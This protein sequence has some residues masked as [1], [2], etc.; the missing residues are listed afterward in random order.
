[1]Y[2]IRIFNRMKSH[3]HYLLGNRSL[4]TPSS[5]MSNTS[6]KLKYDIGIIRKKLNDNLVEKPDGYRRDGILFE[7]VL[8]IIY[9]NEGYK[10]INTGGPGDA[11]VDLI[12]ERDNKKI[13]IQAKNYNDKMTAK[14]LN[15]P[16]VEAMFHKIKTDGEG[17]HLCVGESFHSA[18]IH[19]YNDNIVNMRPEFMEQIAIK[20]GYDIFDKGIYG[21]TWLLNYT[22]YLTR[23]SIAELYELFE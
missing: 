22:N 3:N 9:Q 23:N 14:Y 19:I 18:R 21:K 7:K 13:A 6:V 1:M 17:K 5:C 4:Y 15:K 12:V 11:G 10:T 8:K 16:A 2:V 20:H